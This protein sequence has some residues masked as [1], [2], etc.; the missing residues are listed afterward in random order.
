MADKKTYRYLRPLEGDRFYNVGDT[1]DMSPAEAKHLLDLGVIEEA[2]SE[3]VEAAP[4]NK[5][6]TVAKKK[7]A[8]NDPEA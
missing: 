5:V 2:S 3:K 1:R 8:R 4:A 6:E 7:G